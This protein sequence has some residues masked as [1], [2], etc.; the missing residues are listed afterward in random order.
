M[1]NII[2]ATTPTIKYRFRIVKVTDITTAYLTIKQN[3]N[4][5]IEKTLADADVGEDSLSWTFTQSETLQMATGK[6]T[7]MLNWK[8][9]DG[10]RGASHKST[11]A[12]ECN[13]KE[14]VI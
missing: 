9:V 6:I 14:E 4:T 12:I 8:T 10:T 5:I 13:F 2:R 1:A 7:A 11:V 3:G